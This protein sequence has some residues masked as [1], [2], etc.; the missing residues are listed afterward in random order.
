MARGQS[1]QRTWWDGNST[2]MWRILVVAY[3]GI[4]AFLG[5]W[6]FNQLT[7]L[8]EKYPDKTEL[9]CLVERLD[10]RFNS[11]DNK[12]DRINEYLRESK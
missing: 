12:V 5:S 7:A 6:V 3:M 8:P 4:M 11:L 10:N 1:E 9:R 2:R